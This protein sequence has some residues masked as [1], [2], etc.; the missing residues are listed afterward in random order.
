MAEWPKNAV[1]HIP[2]SLTFVLGMFLLGAWFIR[3]GS[4]DATRRAPGL[5]QEDGDVRHSVRHRLSIVGAAIPPRTC[6]A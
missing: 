4:D 2:F 5:L 3:S 1:G 6:A